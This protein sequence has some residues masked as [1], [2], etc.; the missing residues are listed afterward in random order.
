MGNDKIFLYV[1]VSNSDTYSKS[2]P[3]KDFF[4]KVMDFPINDVNNFDNE[5]QLT[6]TTFPSNKH[7]IDLK[8]CIKWI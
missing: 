7:G 2:L 6:I 1:L 8:E 5:K 3:H 4:L